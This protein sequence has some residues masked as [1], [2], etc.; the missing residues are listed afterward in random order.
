MKI[1]REHKFHIPV[2]G[3]GFSIDV[4]LKVSR[5]GISSVMSLVDD[6]LMEKLREFYLVNS[7]AGYEPINNKDKYARA[8]RITAYLNMINRM[9]KEQFESLKNSAFGK[10]SEINKYFDMLPDFSILKAKF[11]EMNSSKDEGV[12]KRI[13]N[14]LRENMFHGNIDVNIMTKVDKANYSAK[15]ELL[16]NEFNDAH[17][18]LRGFALSELESSV[19]FSAGMNPRLYSYLETFQ[20]FYPDADGNFKKKITM[21][22]SDFRSALIQGKFLAKKGLWISEFRI[23][24]GLNCGGH[25]FATDGLLLGPILE[26]FKTRKDELKEL[27]C[28]IYLKILEQKE[29]TPNHDELD[30]DIT[31]QGGVGKS[32]EQNFLLNYYDVKSVGW[33]SPFLLVPEVMNVDDDTLRKLS[34]AGTDDIYLSDVSPLGVPFYCLRNSSKEIEKQLRIEKGKPGS[35]CP[36]KFLQS[37]REFSERPL[38]TASISYLNKKIRD[39]KKESSCAEKYDD[40][41]KKAVDKTCLCEGLTASALVVKGI[42]P[43]K[44]SSAI[45]VCPGPNLAYFSKITTLRELVDH[46]YGRT[47]LITDPHRPNMF[48]KELS[49]YIDYLLKKMEQSAKPFSKQVEEFIDTFSKNLMDGIK[50]YKQIIPEMLEETERVRQKMY[51]EIEALENK[52]SS[53]FIAAV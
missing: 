19:I 40:E 33:G 51:E 48:V 27:L 39:L 35:H 12:V 8:N 52:L 11:N 31:V 2:L 46:I 41:F 6:T 24:S 32:S 22:V 1:K 28:E 30:F 29:I 25:A 3:V 45:A 38:C 23:E 17:A 4:P 13:E 15:G 21:K 14:W 43:S 37:N 47:D 50:Y 18:A 34:N 10:G 16:P 20:D 36:K 5:Y 7:G 49:L 42:N 26:E 44:Q 53:Y 9:V